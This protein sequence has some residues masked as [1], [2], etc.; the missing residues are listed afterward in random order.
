M[1]YYLP[2]HVF[3]EENCVLT[4]KKELCSMGSKALIVTGKHSSRANHSLEHVELALGSGQIPYAIFDQIEANPSVET[5]MEASKLGLEEK[6]DFVIGVGGGSP[7]DAAKAIALMIANPGKSEEILYERGVFPHLP[8][9]CVPTTAGTGSEVTPYAILTL[10]KEK[11]KRSISHR[12]FPEYAF[13]DAAYL[14]TASRGNLVNTAVDTLAH[15][16]ESYLNANACLYNEI[17]SEKGLS[18]WGSIKDALAQGQLGE[19][20][21]RAL[22]HAS[23]LGGMAISHTGTSLPHGLSY[24]ITYRL[25][26]PHGKAVGRFLGGFVAS[27]EEKES[28]QRLLSLL[29]FSHAQEL[30]DY[31]SKLLELDK[32][33]IPAEVMEIALSEL[34]SNPD[35]LKNYPFQADRSLLERIIA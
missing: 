13:T 3:D 34:L 9:A 28:S 24:P 5:V 31:L 6:V 12:I 11:T 10:H 30:K 16:A 26:I 20:G 18:L 14:K 23:T 4:Y 1:N 33:L 22:M 32:L 19:E 25:G 7:L 21:Y 17:F 27:Y 29:G 35:K 2:T 15:L 8:I